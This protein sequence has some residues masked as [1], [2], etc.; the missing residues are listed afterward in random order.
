MITKKTI[1]RKKVNRNAE[2]TT[3][4]FLS[5]D[6]SSCK[7]RYENEKRVNVGGTKSVERILA[8]L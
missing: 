5:R 3:N 6:G 4:I 1:G 2:P 8:V 7:P